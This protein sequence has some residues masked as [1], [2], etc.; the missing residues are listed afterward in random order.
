MYM[1]SPM[2]S[3]F[4]AYLKTK[5]DKGKEEDLLAELIDVVEERNK[6]VNSMD[7]DRIR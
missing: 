2:K 7:E 5:E 3:G 1:H 6:I 4:E